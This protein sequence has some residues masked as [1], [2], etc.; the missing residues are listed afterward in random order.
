MGQLQQM[1][2]TLMICSVL[3]WLGPLSFVTV[4]LS[5]VDDH[6]PQEVYLKDASIGVEL[7]HGIAV[8]SVSIHTPL[9]PQVQVQEGHQGHSQGLHCNH[10]HV[11][12][13]S[14]FPWHGRTKAWPCEAEQA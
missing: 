6:G 11:T 1:K 5:S 7:V 9:A 10:Q 14:C 8:H 3:K 12:P 2:G 4:E 13:G